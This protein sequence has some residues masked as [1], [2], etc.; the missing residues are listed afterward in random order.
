MDSCGSHT[1]QDFEHVVEVE[2]F[3][4][5]VGVQEGSKPSPSVISAS[6]EWKTVSRNIE[7][8]LRL[9]SRATER[10][11]HCVTENTKLDVVRVRLD[12]AL[13]WPKLAH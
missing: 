2:E 10:V 1:R 7:N 5:A 11:L 4:Q 9:Y 8:I 13:S 12:I 3:L 6:N